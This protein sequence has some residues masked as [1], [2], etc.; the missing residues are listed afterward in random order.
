MKILVI[1]IPILILQSCLSLRVPNT[2]RRAQKKLQLALNFEERLINQYPN[3]ADS[4]KTDTEVDGSVDV[5]SVEVVIQ[6][7]SANLER[8]IAESFNPLIQE[9]DSLLN[10]LGASS[11][12][13]AELINQKLLSNLR[14]LQQSL[15]SAEHIAFPDTTITMVSKVELVINNQKKLIEVV[16]TFKK[17]KGK[18]TLT[19]IVPESNFTLVIETTTVKYNTDQFSLKYLILGLLIGT[20]IG[21]FISSRKNK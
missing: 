16:V 8:F 6:I 2:E 14:K 21:L 9:R 17:E 1:L 15:R 10:L 7:D 3:L 19:A 11:P 20:I 12:A 13:E 5:D 4:I 18:I